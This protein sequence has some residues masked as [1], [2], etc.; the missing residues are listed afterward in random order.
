MKNKSWKLSE[1]NN[2]Y[3]RSSN[4]PPMTDKE[5]AVGVKFL[6]E[7][8]YP[9]PED[10]PEGKCPKFRPACRL[11]ICRIAVGMCGDF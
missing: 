10:C 6:R 5:I 3:S 2:I 11:G 9:K 4:L 7:H 1:W 8:N